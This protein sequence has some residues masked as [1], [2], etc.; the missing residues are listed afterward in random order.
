MAQKQ[1][2]VSKQ[3]Q[4]IDL[5]INTINTSKKVV[6]DIVGDATKV[7][8]AIADLQNKLTDLQTHLAQIP[9]YVLKQVC[10][11]VQ[12]KKK[13]ALA[14]GLGFGWAVVGSHV[15]CHNIQEI[16]KDWQSVTNKIGDLT[17]QENT[18]QARLASNAAKKS[19]ALASLAIAEPLLI[20]AQAQKKLL[21]DEYIFTSKLLD[22]AEKSLDEIQNYIDKRLPTLPDL[23][24][25]IGQ[26]KIESI[27]LIV[28]GKR[29]PFDNV[30]I[31]LKQGHS[32]WF[33]NIGSASPFDLFLLVIESEAKAIQEHFK[34]YPEKDFKRLG[35]RA[36]YYDGHYYR[37]DID[38]EGKLLGFH[39]YN[40]N[41]DKDQDLE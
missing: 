5:Q 4:F 12:D 29:Y 1:Q 34:Q 28:N 23:I 11:T 39:P 36:I 6:N 14:W 25:P 16:S 2:L 21:D 7:P 24:P 27:A 9:M 17:K 20:Q 26:L 37:V 41:D 19:T 31:V 38:K 15:V 10:N 40:N 18:L 35:K 33:G 22:D 30:N 3:K 8:L 32:E 13:Q